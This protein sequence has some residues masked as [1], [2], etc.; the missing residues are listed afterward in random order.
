[1]VNARVGDLAVGKG[2]RILA[3]SRD[4]T[5]LLRDDHRKPLLANHSLG[6]LLGARVDR[7]QVAPHCAMPF[8]FHS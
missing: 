6:D 7:A 2:E 4:A 3:A 1:M 8:Q 5:T